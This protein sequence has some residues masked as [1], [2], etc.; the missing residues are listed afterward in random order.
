MP[1][2]SPSFSDSIQ[3][4]LPWKIFC[5]YLCSRNDSMQPKGR[6]TNIR[7]TL[8]CSSKSYDWIDNQI[9]HHNSYGD[10]P[11]TDLASLKKEIELKRS[12]QSNGKGINVKVSRGTLTFP[13][14][15][16]KNLLKVDLFS[17]I[18]YSFEKKVSRVNVLLSAEN[19]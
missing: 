9:T 10:Y 17:A 8:T 3:L 7:N 12:C 2:S 16:E 5:H 14:P 11:G 19:S 15:A 4:A 18:V 6:T 13:S 1:S